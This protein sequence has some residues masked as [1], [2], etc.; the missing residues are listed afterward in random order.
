LSR[1]AHDPD[2]MIH[3][4][5]EASHLGASREVRGLGQECI[6]KKGGRSRPFRLQPEQT[7]QRLENWKLARALRWPY[8]LRSTT[9]ESRVRKPSF[10]SAGLRSGS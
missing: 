9:R 3:G 4:A 5:N 8:F 7:A 1:C 6:K 10:L 2:R